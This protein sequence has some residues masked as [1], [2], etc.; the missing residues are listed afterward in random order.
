MTGPAS[1]PPE[2]GDRR[3]RWW[4]DLA[5]RLDLIGR[6]AENLEGRFQT[7]WVPAALLSFPILLL[8]LALLISPLR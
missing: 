8:I 3:P 7:W 5:H 1:Q 4:T 2:D 6:V